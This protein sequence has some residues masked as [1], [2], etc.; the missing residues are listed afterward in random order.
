[1]KQSLMILGR[2]PSI[3][4]VELESLFS[5]EKLQTLG[6][7][8]AILDVEAESVPFS[9]IGGS[10]KLGKIVHEFKN[11]DWQEI[12]DYLASEVPKHTCCIGPGKFTFGISA[13]GHSVKPKDIQKTSLIVKKAIVKSDKRSV[14]VVM[15]TKG[16]ELSSAQ[17]L[18]NSLAKSPFGMELII[19]TDGTKTVLAQTTNFQDIEAYAARDQKRPKRDAKVGM[20][21]PKLAQ[22]IINLAV[23][24]PGAGDRRLETLNNDSHGLDATQTT[25]TQPLHEDAIESK[26]SL[27]LDASQ[28]SKEKRANRTNGT[29]SKRQTPADT[30]MRQEHSGELAAPP[31]SSLNVAVTVLDP[32]C[33]TGVILQES[34]LMNYSAFGTDIDLRMVQYSQENIE[35]L[36]NHFAAPAECHVTVGDATMFD[37]RG[38]FTTVASETYLGRPFSHTPDHTT[39]KKVMQDVDTIHKK[40]L[41]N[42]A[43]QTTKGFRLCLAVPAWKTKEGFL[44]IGVLDSLEKLGYTRLSFKHARDED[45][46]YHREGQIVGRQLLVLQRK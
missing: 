17:L 44:H 8:A 6:N 10:I 43:K 39:L 11:N 9:R 28:G 1:M 41:E 30:V 27:G 7:T 46:I 2:Q 34:L 16:T 22:I 26:N 18:H 4:L 33:G 15:P 40:F 24:G 38:D 31:T 35:W 5:A 45:L 37:W 19:A 29:K 32:F 20:L 36:K 25:D 3:S 42:L 23:N 12:T 14:R 21:P 13:Y